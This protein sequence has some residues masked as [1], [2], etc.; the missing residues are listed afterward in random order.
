MSGERRMATQTQSGPILLGNMTTVQLTH[1]KAK[2]F[3]KHLM[4]AA[5]ESFALSE[6]PIQDSEVYVIP[7]PIE[8]AIRQNSAWTSD[9]AWIGALKNWGALAVNVLSAEAVFRLM[10]I[11]RV[12]SASTDNKPVHLPPLRS[13]PLEL[14]GDQQRDLPLPFQGPFDWHL[15]CCRIPQAWAIFA[16]S[17]MHQNALP[18]GDIVV[19]LPDTGYS[20]HNALGWS[21]GSSV[22]VNPNL[23]YDFFDKDSDPRDPFLPSGNPGHGTR[24]SAAIA[25]F[26]PLAPDR[27][28]YGGAPGAAIIPYRV[29]DSVLID[30]VSRLVAQAIND[31]VEKACDVVSVSLG[32]LFRDRKMADALDRAYEAGV[33]VVCAAGN[34]WG[35][36]IYPGRYNRCVTM[37]GIGPGDLPWGGSAHG[38]YVD[39][40]GP[41]QQ[42]RRI[43]P[44]GL[45]PGQTASD[46][47]MPPDG[48]GTSYAT[49]QCASVAVLWLARHGKTA[50]QA[51]YP[52]PWMKV[53]AFK[54]L[55]RR[56]ARVPRGWDTSQYGSGIID[57]EALLQAPLPAADDLVMALQANDV[58]DPND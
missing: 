35:E 39:L 9:T 10:E 2:P 41:A 11:G 18:W 12:K 57:A 33:I 3:L 40:C 13:V 14:M 55:L 49:A 26:N 45:P 37:G 34:Y 15:E 17:S 5:K 50:L 28:F 22:T 58:F 27:P 56:T 51:A 32:A 21:G 6:L 31:A 46:I 43:K 53:A 16:R 29:T 4:A 20:E 44:S 8:D 1:E 54:A 42:V 48:V 30:H 25:G 19:G 52:E 23:G 47:Y 7:K 24:M 38:Q 36:V